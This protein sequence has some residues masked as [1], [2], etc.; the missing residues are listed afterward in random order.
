[1]R[2]TERV[3]FVG[4]GD[5]G[6]RGAAVHAPVLLFVGDDI[7]HRL[8]VDGVLTSREWCDPRSSGSGSQRTWQQ[9]FQFPRVFVIRRRDPYFVTDH[10]ESATNLATIV[11]G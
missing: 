8:T 10:A 1:M 7:C 9:L 11:V 3:P 2:Q 6:D 5:D 4:N